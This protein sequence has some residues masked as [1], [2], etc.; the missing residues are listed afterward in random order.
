MASS[1]DSDKSSSMDS[2]TG[3]RLSMAYASSLIIN[4]LVKQLMNI[5]REEKL[6]DRDDCNSFDCLINFVQSLD[7]GITNSLL[8]KKVFKNFFRKLRMVLN[9]EFDEGKCAKGFFDKCE[10]SVQ[11]ALF[12]KG[13]VF[14]KKNYMNKTVDLTYFKPAHPDRFVSAEPEKH[15]RFERYCII[16]PVIV[17]EDLKCKNGCLDYEDILEE[18]DKVLSIGKA[19]FHVH[20]LCSCHHR[21]E[22]EDDYE[23][24]ESIA[25]V[26]ARDVGKNN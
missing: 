6:K 11:Q 9:K 20:E 4:S 15:Q 21:H 1:I 23:I 14:D 2:E 24:P 10:T 3:Y 16:C 25:K 12:K 18:R 5:I 13:N 22:N 19:F 17:H 26:F 7:E 8:V